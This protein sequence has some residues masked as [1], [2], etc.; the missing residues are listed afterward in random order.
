MLERGK[1]CT[2]LRARGILSK[3]LLQFIPAL[4]SAEVLRLH[5]VETLRSRKFFRAAT[6]QHHVQR[7]FHHRARQQDR[8]LD[9][10]HFRHRPGSERRAIHDRRIQCVL[11]VVGEYGALAGIEQRIILQHADGGG[12][13]ITWPLARFQLRIAVAQRQGQRDT[14][15][16]RDPTYTAYPYYDVSWFDAAGRSYY[17][18]F[19]YKFG[20][21]KL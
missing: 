11:A 6:H 10:M 18:Q 3:R 13:R 7:M 5:Q 15:P 14:M 8:I 12:H 4:D 1:R 21:S 17:L 2:R 19:T 9:A 16:P 20:G